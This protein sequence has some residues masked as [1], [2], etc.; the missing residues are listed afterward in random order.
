MIP[1]LGKGLSNLLKKIIRAGRVDKEEVE[2]FIKELQRILLQADVSV[3]LVKKISDN[4]RRKC[5]KEKIP[6][7]VT[8]REHVVKVL[9]DELVELLGK[10]TSSLLGKRRIMLIGLFGSGK[11]TSAAKLARYFQKQGLK[12][13]LVACDYHRPAAPEQLKQ[14]GK[15]IGV[16]VYI[17]EDKDPYKAAKTAIEKLKKID[18]LIFDTAGRDALD[19]K[20]AEELKKLG[21]IINPDE[22]L[23]VIPADIGKIGGRQA[24][25]FNKL[26]GITGVLITRMDGTAKGGGAL[27][28]CSATG[29]KVKFIG[30]GEKLEDLEAYDP[31]RFVSRLLGM[32][33][34][35]TLL[36]KLKEVEIK[37]KEVEKIVEGKFTLQDF[38]NQINSIGKMGSLSSIM[39]MIP[40][41]SYSLPEDLLKAQEDKI[42]K[43]KVIIQSMTLEERENPEIINSSRIRRIAKGCGCKESE[44]REL[45]RQY[46]Q[47]KKMMKKLGGMKGLKRGALLKLARKFGLKL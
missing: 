18:V 11:T 25:E 37:E 22:V 15:K 4:I 16:P 36:E 27:A 31:V 28:A 32:G 17:D 46:T 12:P 1:T 45:L 5:L 7:G 44:V 24:E 43:W 13:A 6:P 35:Q 8:L 38:Y 14:L 26:I 10:E 23:L 40:G 20:L 42:K 39:Q 33:D 41:F 21:K 3:D 34:L 29:A 9:Y 47:T 19:K 2:S 30:V